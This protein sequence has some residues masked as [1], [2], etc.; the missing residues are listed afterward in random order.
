MLQ[1][2]I[3]DLDNT[4]YPASSGLLE[5]VGERV[6]SFIREELGLSDEETDA[7]RY[8]YWKE[9]GNTARGLALH[10]NIDPH[11]FLQYIH[12]IEL[13]TFIEVNK[14]LDVLLGELRLQKVVFT[15]SP[16]EYAQRI[17]RVL[18][19]AHH[20]TKIY[21][22]H[23]L[24]FVGKPNRE[25]YSFIIQ[26]TQVLGSECIMLDDSLSNLLVAQDFGMQTVLVGYHGT[27]QGSIAAVR[28]IQPDYVAS[29]I[30]DAI[31]LTIQIMSSVGIARK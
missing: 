31:K 9:Y 1:L 21:D 26:D 18:G 29:D 11:K 2:A 19:I 16:A 20:F 24:N 30:I 10:H 4:L 8:R 14:E 23:S 3:F 7:L 6:A 13:N 28:P 22:L 12:E 27:P 17:L 25:A 5:T 15:N